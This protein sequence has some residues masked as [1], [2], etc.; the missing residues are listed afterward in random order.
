MAALLC[1]TVT[2]QGGR[3]PDESELTAARVRM[4]PVLVSR[5][6]RLSGGNPQ[7]A[8]AE[9]LGAAH[10][11][12]D[13]AV[14]YLLWREAVGLAEG[15]GDLAFA[16]NLELTFAAEF[17]LDPV[18]RTKALLLRAAECGDRTRAASAAL[19]GLAIATEH[20]PLA[21]E[22]AMLAIYDASTRA[23][24][25]CENTAVFVFVRDRLAT[26]RDQRAVAR[27]LQA[28]GTLD[29][30]Q[31]ASLVVALVRGALPRRS[32]LRIGELRP[33]LEIDAAMADR[34]A[35]SLTPD[36]WSALAEHSDTLE[37][38]RALWRCAATA[39]MLHL[40]GQGTGRT[41][42]DPARTDLH[43]LLI[44]ST[45]RLAQDP[46]VTRL[47]FVADGDRE[48]LSFA[49]GD[50]RVAQGA[51]SGTATGADNFATHRVRF[52]VLRT[53]VIRGGIR[54]ADGLNF[55]CKVGDV[56][57]LLNWEVADENHLW[58]NGQ[59]FAVRPRLLEQGKEHTIAFFAE[60]THCDVCVDGRLVWSAPLP[61]QLA[62]TITVYPALGSEIFV[63]EILID[64][65]PD[66]VVDAP[67]GPLM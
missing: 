60:G 49:N 18:D 48:Q 55:R 28:A 7:R 47:S 2:G 23:A 1:A 67:I 17:G 56:N 25:A 8:A 21:D 59:R 43:Q 13:A 39:T 12:D 29:H 62:G 20:A 14:R 3:E 9:L 58:L 44:A 65:D 53:V 40:R 50:W 54:S 46:G 26:L 6:L 51:L 10:E 19:F 22:R 45:E 4:A 61:S 36:E 11:S 33:A 52:G 57:L 42:H 24:L 16:H 64:G 31:I 5:L 35:G 41:P 34:D 63:R 27:A 15:A 38:R 30:E 32:D 66:G 37:L